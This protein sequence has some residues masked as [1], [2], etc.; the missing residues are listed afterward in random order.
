MMRLW[1]SCIA[2]LAINL[3][4]LGI[5][6]ETIGWHYWRGYN[7]VGNFVVG[8]AAAAQA[9]LNLL[10]LLGVVI[11]HRHRARPAMGLASWG[12]LLAMFVVL[13]SPL[14]APVVG[15]LAAREQWIETSLYD[16]ARYGDAELV[17]ILLAHGASPNDPK[18]TITPLHYIAARDEVAA[19]RA[20]IAKGANANAT[21]NPQRES[22]LHFALRGL[23]S[24]VMIALLV[25]H[26]ADPRVIDSEGRTPANYV[27]TY[28]E[29]SRLE[30]LRALGLYL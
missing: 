4:L 30:V 2:I 24:P 16:A 18:A 15:R 14:I 21:D 29:Q 8:W 20:L 10:L 19:A 27:D 11:F 7:E 23:A 6:Y 12:L 22:P 13:I 26:G 3:L 28:D 25:K 5:M 9:G 17:E 1:I